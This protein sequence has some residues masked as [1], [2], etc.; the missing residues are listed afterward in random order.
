MLLTGC[1]NEALDQKY[2][3]G[4][5]AMKSEDYTGAVQLFDD[6][7]EAEYRLP[8]A[9][10]S[11]GLAYM[12]KKEYPEA[13]AAFSRSLLYMEEP[14][15]PFEKDAMFYLAEAR[16]QYGEIEKAVQVYTDILKIEENAEA[17]FLRGKG[18]FA[19]GD[20]ERA[21]KDFDRA[22]DGCRDYEW[23]M[24]IYQIY[25]DQD[26]KAEG[27]EY[28][29]RALELTPENGED[30]YQRGRIFY[31]Q[32]NYES[33]EEE[34]ILAVQA[35]Y[36]DAVLLLGNIYLETEDSA[37]A[38]NMYQEYLKK[39]ENMAIAYNGLAMCDIHEG[40]YDQALINIENGLANSTPETQK[41]LLYNEI[42]AYEYKLD[43]ATAK[44]KM[45]AYL[46][47]YPDDAEAL[48]ENEFLSTR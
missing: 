29:N 47:L 7:I 24:N 21:K 12:K 5:E 46:E 2:T 11:T 27:N 44:S 37:S 38:R 20:Y 16:M 39:E 30:Y 28:L 19:L 8:E 35:D 41:G 14:D 1:G 40:N 10:R 15:I 3:Q 22:L 25:A 34:L 31:R 13:I 17:F 18:Y 26:K 45:A 33:A 36:E 9:Y 43:F 42:V 48:R 4:M 23:Y 32:G 6:L